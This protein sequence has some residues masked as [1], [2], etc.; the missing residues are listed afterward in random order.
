MRAGFPEIDTTPKELGRLGRLIAVP[1]QV[2]AVHSP[3]YARLGV[4]DDGSCRAAIL[5]LQEQSPF[6]T[7]LFAAMAN[8][9]H[10][11]IPPP[12]SHEHGGYETCVGVASMFEPDASPTLEAV[13]LKMLKQLA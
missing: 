6:K 11:Y 5:S 10:G 13:A 2:E 12:A 3:L 7:T 9:G 8:G 1:T 4:F